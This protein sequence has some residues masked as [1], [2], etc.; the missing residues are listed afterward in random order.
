MKILYGVVGEGMGHATRSRVILDHLTKKH[1]V[2]VVASGRAYDFLSAR[3]PNVQKIWGF[4][5]AYEENAVSALRT[6]MQNVTGAVKGWPENV[7]Q[8]FEIKEQFQPD[9]VVSDFESF[10]YLYARNWRLPVISLD[11]IQMINRCT[12]PPGI[13]EGFERE[14]QLTKGIVK[15]KMPGAYHYLVSTFF[16][17]EVRKQRTSLHP[18]VLR[19][20]ILEAKPERGEHLLVYQTTTTNTELPKVLERSGLECRI[21]GLR[22]DLREEQVEGRL[23]Y[24]P[25]SE[26]GFIDDLRT[27]RG[28]VAS[29]G[30]TLMS[31][32]VYLHKPM[33]S[34]PL[35][36]Q[37]E[38]ILNA[39]Y[40]ER[41]GYGRY[42]ETLTDEA[43]AAF[44]ERL[45]AAER[46]L[47]GY[48][49]DGNRA[50]LGHLDA[51]LAEIAEGR[52]L[53]PESLES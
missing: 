15:S 1:E 25:F 23:R 49:Q 39:R 19:P 34:I 11:N 32:A 47:A 24:R 30:F 43:L 6:A 21:Y 3:F 29:G 48:R 41:E 31:E 37:F 26:Q 38:Q 28:V 8:Y 44:L 52:G 12:H 51:L 9:C 53:S 35:E 4:T 22:R 18:S 36:G 14:F 17:P 40:L 50:L 20:E 2:Y 16:Y 46:R 13:L 45:P 42:A 5:I 33:L 27:A 7:R 10:A